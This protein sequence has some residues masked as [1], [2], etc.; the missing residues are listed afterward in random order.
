M[1]LDL[2]AVGRS[3]GQGTTTRAVSVR[4]RPANRPKLYSPH[5]R[6]G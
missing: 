6:D 4:D 3:R 2:R 5:Q 1:V